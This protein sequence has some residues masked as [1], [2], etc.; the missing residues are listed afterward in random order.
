M[1]KLSF[2]FLVSLLMVTSTMMAQIENDTVVS[3]YADLEEIIVQSSRVRNEGSLATEKYDATEL[4]RENIGTNLPFLLLG[5]PSLVPT[6][7]DGLGV[8]YSYFRIR[9]TDHTRINMTVNGVPLNDSESQTV[10]WVNMT[11]LANSMESVE[12]QRGVGTSTNGQAAF[13]AS[14]NMQTQYSAM[15][16]YAMLGFNGGMYN[17]FKETVKMGTGLLGGKFAFDARF[18]KVNTDGYVR[19]AF[20]DLYSYY[21]SG[22]YYGDKTVVKLLFFGGKEK[23][24]MAWDGIDEE[25]LKTDRRYNP[26]GQ[27]LDDDGNVA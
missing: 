3:Q 18:S 26:A 19:R 21:A 10:F 4:N 6:S 13:G 27:Y 9:G 11:D 20:S 16:P 14:V 7:D 25:T 8:G 17:T 5:S 15:E 22:A 23:T 2:F 1:R 24:Y 12:V